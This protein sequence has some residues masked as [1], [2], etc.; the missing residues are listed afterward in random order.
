M[1]D[2]SGPVVEPGLRQ[3][4]VDPLAAYLRPSGGRRTVGLIIGVG[5]VEI[6]GRWFT[7][8]TTGVDVPGAPAA[9]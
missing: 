3:P 7:C 2:V 8:R 6:G 5:V 9:P 1:E 4:A